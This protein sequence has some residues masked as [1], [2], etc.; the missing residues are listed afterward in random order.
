MSENR[1]VELGA[2]LE[3]P[4]EIVAPPPPGEAV[5]ER[6]EQNPPPPDYPGAE[7][8]F[9]LPED[10]PVQALGV[11][12]RAS[13][14]LDACNQMIELADGQ[15][16]KS[17]LDHLFAPHVAYILRQWPAMRWDKESGSYVPK[18]GSADYDRISKALMIAAAAKGPFDPAEKVR[19]RGAWIGADGELVLHCGDRLEIFPR[20]EHGSS[21]APETVKPGSRGGHVYPGLA[22]L[23]GPQMHPA[24]TTGAQNLY[25]ILQSWGWERGELDAR[26]L[27]GWI[28]A[29]FVCGALN[30]RVMVWLTG[31]KASGKSTLQDLLKH[32]FGPGLR[33]V[34]DT[35]A[36]GV[37]QVLGQD[38]IPVAI[39]E[40]EADETSSK[41]GREVQEL[42][43]RASSGGKR[44][45]GGADHKAVETAVRSAFLFSSILIPPMLPQD[46]SRIVVL[47]LGRLRDGTR[48][49]VLTRREL[50][51]IG[52]ELCRRMAAGWWRFQDLMESYRGELTR[53][54]H[55]S[56][57]C[58]QY[59]TLLAAADLLLHDTAPDSDSRELWCQTL[60]AVA[61]EARSGEQSD[62]ERCLQHLL[63][64]PLDIYKDGRK[65]S[66]ADWIGQ[67]A[68][69]S[70]T[71]G[72]DN[73]AGAIGAVGL[74]VMKEAGV[75]VLFIPNSH[76]GLLPLFENTP[77]HGR[78]GAVGAWKQ[79][80]LRLPGALN[81]SRTVRVCRL[82]CRGFFIPLPVTIGEEIEEAD[83]L[84]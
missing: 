25:R 26:L 82:P 1:I 61:I 9:D 42:A 45:R 77:W 59:G 17:H 64:K 30:W 8:N 63:S 41:R 46:A 3:A 80:L 32:L 31:D 22:R 58:D 44:L 40:L 14:Y 19:G 38:S 2:Y 4:A 83:R 66:L 11:S 39:D 70:S 74:R 73:A 60:D 54:G 78:P 69:A 62:A 67:A 65:R 52:A 53:R 35:T 76:A 6:T 21:P 71:D 55:D 47:S 16:G 28:G 15:H 81:A 84:T 56:R 10:C 24:G 27:L 43:R 34:S 37:A 7:E 13:I 33:A 36:T 51:A 29:A 5:P 12:G 23:T 68:F 18:P 72:R 79:A 48:P 57:G 50:T 75:D 20:S 49:P